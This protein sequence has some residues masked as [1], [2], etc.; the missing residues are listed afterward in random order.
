MIMFKLIK[1]T[2]PTGHLNFLCKIIRRDAKIGEDFGFAQEIVYQVHGFNRL[3][4]VDVIYED[5]MALQGVLVGATYEE[6]G[7]LTLTHISSRG[8]M[9]SWSMT[10]QWV[11]E[12]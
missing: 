2:R 9:A 12:A 5:N 11:E 10:F 6:E 1:S 7:I 8:A 4:V 3:H